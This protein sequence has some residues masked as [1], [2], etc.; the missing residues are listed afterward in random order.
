MIKFCFVSALS[1]FSLISFAQIGEGQGEV[2]L[3]TYEGNG[4]SYGVSYYSGYDRYQSFKFVGTVQGNMFGPIYTERSNKPYNI[5][6]GGV[7]QTAQTSLLGQVGLDRRYNI[8]LT[9]RVER[10]FVNVGMNNG[11][12]LDGENM[13]KIGGGLFVL[14]K[15]LNGNEYCTRTEG[16]FNKSLAVGLN[17]FKWADGNQ[18]AYNVYISYMF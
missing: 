10:F 9:Q 5:F 4:L 12:R 13:Y 7:V 11:V 15:V 16:D 18:W 1:F 2:F 6:V 3:N 8:L 14:D 17:M